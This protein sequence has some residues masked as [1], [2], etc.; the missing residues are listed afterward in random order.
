MVQHRAYKLR[1]DPVGE[2]NNIFSD[3]GAFTLNEFCARYGLS[4]SAAYREINAQRLI[5][6]KR[7]SRTVIERTEA[8]QWFT[9]LPAFESRTAETAA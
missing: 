1:S 6:K 4:R 8:R 7:G 9:N 2:A 5:A 3:D